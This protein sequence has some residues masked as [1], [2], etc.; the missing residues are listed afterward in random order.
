MQIFLSTSFSSQVD[1]ASGAVLPEYRTFVT[2]VL[3]G[4]RREEGEVYCAIE[5]EGWKVSDQPPEVSIKSDLE[6][7]D[8]SDV[9]I[10]LIHDRPSAGVQFE[11][12]YAVAK[13]KRVIIARSSNDGLSYF[14]QGIVG[15]GLVTH[16]SY[17]NAATLLSQLAVALHAPS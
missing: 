11:L 15:A 8:V 3:E 9:L 2:N 4:L 13:A 16:L 12:G 7:I 1:P 17:D 10:A 14:N 5:I 6:H